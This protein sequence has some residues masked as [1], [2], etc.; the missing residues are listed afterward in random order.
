MTLRCGGCDQH[1]NIAGKWWLLMRR[2]GAD[3]GTLFD[4]WNSDLM[5]SHVISSN[6]WPSQS[7]ASRQQVQ[8]VGTNAIALAMCSANNQEV[9]SLDR[10]VKPG[11]WQNLHRP[12]P[13]FAR[14]HNLALAEF[15]L[16][17]GQKWRQTWSRWN[18]VQRASNVGPSGCCMCSD[19]TSIVEGTGPTSFQWCRIMAE[20]RHTFASSWCTADFPIWESDQL[21]LRCDFHHCPPRANAGG[22]F[23]RARQWDVWASVEHVSQLQIL[24]HDREPTKSSAVCSISVK[25]RES[26]IRSI[27]I[28]QRATKKTVVEN[29][30]PFLTLHWSS[31]ISMLGLLGSRGSPRYICERSCWY[32]ASASPLPSLDRWTLWA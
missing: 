4:G 6:I 16:P 22:I 18:W 2:K 32:F 9:I 28:Q 5:W 7:E 1:L 14:A 12:W 8:E 27:K 21:L 23:Q 20:L 10:W 11:F 24:W 15:V 25:G 26:Y 30:P 13:C 29:K 17:E 3:L 31:W 19:W